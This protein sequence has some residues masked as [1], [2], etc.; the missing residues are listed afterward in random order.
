MANITL[1]D[2]TGEPTRLDMFGYTYEV[3]TLTRSVQKKL[4][5]IQPLLD[6]LE[7]EEDADK[8][9]ATMVDSIDALLD[10]QEN[11]PA[12]KKI[13]VEAWKADKLDLGVVRRMFDRVQEAAVARP[14]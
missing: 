14:T 5:K 1:A 8:V 2:L 9:V 7:D 11:A 4:E 12:A 10:P 13:L 6:T 3:L